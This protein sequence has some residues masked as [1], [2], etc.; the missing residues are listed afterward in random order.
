MSVGARTL[1]T[2]IAVALSMYICMIFNIE[3][4][5]FA[6]AATVVNLQQSIGKSFRNAYE[7]VIVHFFSVIVAILLGL[8]ITFKP[9]SMGLATIIIITICTKTL[10]WNRSIAMGVIA[11][12]FILGAPAN[13][14][15]QHALLRSLAIFIGLGVALVINAFISP[16]RYQQ[17]LV[18]K[19]IELNLLASRLFTDAV[20]SFLNLTLPSAEMKVINETDYIKVLEETEKYYELYAQEWVLGVVNNKSQKHFYNEYIHYNQGLAQRAKDILFLAGERKERRKTAQEPPISPEFIEILDLLMDAVQIT[21]FYNSQLH[22]KVKGEETAFFPEPR[23]W[24]K[25][26]A[27]INHWHDRFPAGSYYLH[28]LI[29]IALVTYKIRWNAK[30]ASRLLS[31]NVDDAK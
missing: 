16:P 21:S 15:L 17:V 19:L 23:I 10:K 6:A 22:K 20:N 25:L 13:E 29:E 24:S 5:I 4:A 30:E 18:G 26:E 9:L 27:I 14:F 11:A 1:K 2:G 12:I 3:P 28:A 7:Q 31:L 8:T